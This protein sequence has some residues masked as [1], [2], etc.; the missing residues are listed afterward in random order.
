MISNSK[1]VRDKSL[2]ICVNIEVLFQGDSSGPVCV[3]P[4]ANVV[5]KKY[6]AQW[7]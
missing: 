4:K 2:Y 5:I 1:L 3:L 6:V 7:L